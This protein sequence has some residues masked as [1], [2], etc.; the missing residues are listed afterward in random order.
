[1]CVRMCELFHT[2]WLH[3]ADGIPG[4]QFMVFELGLNC[5]DRVCLCARVCVCERACSEGAERQTIAKKKMKMNRK[6]GKKGDMIHTFRWVAN[7]GDRGTASAYS[8][9]NNFK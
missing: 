1:M 7:G 9:F 8:Q 3:T 6:N 2:G 4:A 5:G